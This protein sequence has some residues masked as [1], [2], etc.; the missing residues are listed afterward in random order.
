[1]R[2]QGVVLESEIGG[3]MEIE[4][5]AWQRTPAGSD[6][7]HFYDVEIYMGLCSSDQLGS[8]F[9]DNWVPGTKT[10]VFSAA[11]LDLAAAAN[12][13]E[14][15]ILSTPY[16]YDGQQNLLFEVTW[17]SAST[18]YSFY[19]WQWETGGARTAYATN[20]GS[21]TGILSTKLSMLQFDGVL[22]LDSVTFGSLK[23]AFRSEGD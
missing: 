2:Y 17:Q 8:T 21:A 1:M 14:A 18:S 3:A 5:I 7:G 23:A 19:T 12:E 10:L 13:W 16:W 4:S 22:A 15:V 20:L 6:Q 11:Q 9:A